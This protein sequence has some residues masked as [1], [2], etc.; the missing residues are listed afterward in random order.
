MPWAL[1]LMP[2]PV[3]LETVIPFTEDRMHASY[4]PLAVRRWWQ[5]LAQTERVMQRFRGRFL[6]KQSPA[7]FFW[8]SFDLATTRF[9]GR[10]AP[11]YPGVVPHTPAYVMVE[12]Y[13]HECSSCGFWP[14]GGAVHEPAFYAYAYPEPPGYAS[15]PVRPATAAYD[16]QIHEFILP[17]AAVRSTHDPDALLLQFMQSTYDAAADQGK[18]DRTA[19]ER[20]RKKWP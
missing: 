4:D 2:I 3:E 11:R 19:L 12:A 8:G 9:S 1:A 10:A 13:S 16:A 5:I 20:P 6:G 17:Y 14:G 7:H 15:H 18:W